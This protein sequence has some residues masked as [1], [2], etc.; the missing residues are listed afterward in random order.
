[1]K[2]TL[3]TYDTQHAKTADIC[4]QLR[5]AREIE[6]LDFLLVPFTPRPE[7]PV[8]L[9][10]RPDQFTGPTIRDL[11]TALGGRIWEYDRRAEA[12]ER[13]D[14]LL[15]GGANILEP[16]LANCGKIINAH[17][18]LIPL[19]RGLDSF[20][21]AILD[22][23]PIGNT[24]HFIDAEADAGSVIHQEMTPLFANDTIETFAERHYRLELAMLGRFPDHL[25]GGTKLELELTEARKRM[26]AETEKQMLAAFE[27]YKAKFA[28]ATSP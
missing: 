3:I 11:A 17:A 2:V 24:L 27:G 5:A 14:Y 22:G 4:Y 8:L 23:K 18:G 9:R 16:E 21:W 28:M 15:V 6:S 1:M 25:S 12:V 19:V 10:H 20:K 26:P 13:S 7:R